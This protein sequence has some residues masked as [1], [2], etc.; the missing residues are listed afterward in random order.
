[1]GLLPFLHGIIVETKEVARGNGNI[2]YPVLVVDSTADR[3]TVWYKS[4][5]QCLENVK[6]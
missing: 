1:M 2:D 5:Y 6:F 4:Y 3:A